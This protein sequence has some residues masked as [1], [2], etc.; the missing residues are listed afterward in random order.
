MNS[1]PNNH[2]EVGTWVLDPTSSTV[3]FRAKALFGMKV[4]GHFDHY[5][6]SIVVGADG[7]SSSVSV[8]VR[9]DSVST[10]SKK[11]DEHLRSRN[12]FSVGE[13]PTIEFTSTSIA[14]T[15]DGVDV[16]GKLRVRDVTLP[17][18]LKAVRTG[19]N[20]YT[21]ETVVM[22]KE[23]GITRPGTGKPLTIVID[24]ALKRV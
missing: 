15:A 10:G 18:T 24:A 11:R 6:S 9:S 4:K 12:A 17:V 23:F 3:G 14:G 1:L 5:E 16:V 2:P 19:D 22:P 8:S 20:R 7:A 21:A 13:F